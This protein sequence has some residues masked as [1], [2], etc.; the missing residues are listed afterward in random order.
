MHKFF[1]DLETTVSKCFRSIPPKKG[2]RTSIGASVEI[3]RHI[4]DNIGHVLEVDLYE[5]KVI[6]RQSLCPWMFCLTVQVFSAMIILG[7]VL[8]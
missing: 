2:K 6:A 7:K 4:L 3:F 5:K 8:M 1:I